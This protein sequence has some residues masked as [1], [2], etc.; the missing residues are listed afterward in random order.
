MIS[1][2]YG[3]ILFMKNAGSF[4]FTNMQKRDSEV[5]RKALSTAFDFI[6]SCSLETHLLLKLEGS[7]KH[8]IKDMYKIFFKLLKK[9]KVKIVGIKVVNKISHNGC[10]KKS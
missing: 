10:R 1:N 9:S 3:Q 2:T 8:I 6:L 5:L 4:G 7:K